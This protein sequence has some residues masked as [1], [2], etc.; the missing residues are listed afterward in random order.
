MAE[1]FLRW[2]SESRESVR[3][4]SLIN[5][6]ARFWIVSRLARECL[7]ASLHKWERI[8]DRGGFG[9][10]RLW[11]D[12]RAWKIAW[13]WI[14]SQSSLLQ[15]SPQRKCVHSKTDQMRQLYWKD[16]MAINGILVEKNS[17]LFKKHSFLIKKKKKKKWKSSIKVF[18]SI[19][20][21]S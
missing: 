5:L 16:Q 21:K 18:D 12:A 17:Y 9:P 13:T 6:M 8:R 4:E 19:Y 11:G 14:R 3:V 7:E 2:A 20:F 1:T 15:I 10:C